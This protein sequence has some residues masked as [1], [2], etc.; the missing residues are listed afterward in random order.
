M[1]EM[2]S[3]QKCQIHVSMTEPYENWVSSDRTKQ[4]KQNKNST[5]PY[6]SNK[7]REKKG[8]DAQHEQLTTLIAQIVRIYGLPLIR[9]LPNPA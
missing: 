8:V 9:G 5:F 2:F 4:K 7:E 6:G 3:Q 1:A